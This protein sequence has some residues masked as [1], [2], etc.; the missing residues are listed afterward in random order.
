MTF[1]FVEESLSRRLFEISILRKFNRSILL[2]M[3]QNLPDPLPKNVLKIFG[4][5]RR[6]LKMCLKIQKFSKILEIPKFHESS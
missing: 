1:F 2:I 3:F 4:T 6:F 5:F